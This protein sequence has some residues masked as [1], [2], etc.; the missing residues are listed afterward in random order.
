MEL[1]R[2]HNKVKRATGDSL[3]FSK[4]GLISFSKDLAEKL[5][6][7]E[8]SKISFFYEKEKPQDWYFNISKDGDTEI[9]TAKDGKSVFNAAGI[10][11]DIL[12]SIGMEQLAGF[13][14]KI[15]GPTELE[16]PKMTIY[17]LITAALKV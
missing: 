16:E 9:R 2:A 12:K 10:R 8:G 14:V 4:A 3:S 1:V 13:N 15:G 5:K 6:L 7:E 17:P 11:L